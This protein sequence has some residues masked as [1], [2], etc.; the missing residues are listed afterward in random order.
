MVATRK[1]NI[2]WKMA[3]VFKNLAAIHRH[4][5]WVDNS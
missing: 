4:K 1:F 2:N 3:K 5:N